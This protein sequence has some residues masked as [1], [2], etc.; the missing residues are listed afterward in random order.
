MS[1]WIKCSERLPE[2]QYQV[3]LV[4]G[5]RGR[6]RVAMFW[7]ALGTDFVKWTDKGTGKTVKVT[8]W[9]RLPDAP[10][11]ERGDAE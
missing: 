3:C 10:E 8:H 9:M 7:Q 11:V 4:C 1:E 2:Y 6:I 5:P